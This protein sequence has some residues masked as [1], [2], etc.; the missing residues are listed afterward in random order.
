MAH[1]GASGVVKQRM[2]FMKGMGDAMKVLAAMYK[3]EADFDPA[4]A[5]KAAKTIQEHAPRLVE[6]FP[7]G[8]NDHPSEA[9]DVIWTDWSR[10][11]EEAS[12]LEAASTVFVT[13]LQKAAVK[14]TTLSAFAALGKACG[15]CHERFRVKKRRLRQDQAAALTS[16]G[17]RRPATS[18]SPCRGCAPADA[19]RPRPRSVH[20]PLR[21]AR[22]A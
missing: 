6:Q 14:D 1:Q 11:E 13:A 19:H 10:F 22:R 8:T 9:L 4:A 17:Y 3:G 5:L 21:C 15:A 12:V 2:D 18:R 16:P 7:E 20:R